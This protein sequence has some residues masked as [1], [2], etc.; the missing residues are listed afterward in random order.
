MKLKS[1]GITD[2]YG[3]EI[4]EGDILLVKTL[5][6]GGRLNEGVKVLVYSYLEPFELGF[7]FRVL[8]DN[9][10]RDYGVSYHFDRP[11]FNDVLFI[12]GQDLKTLRK[13]KGE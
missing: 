2:F 6:Y 9:F 11:D 4:K 12:V 1:T 13:I 5:S 3:N 10:G 8:P 7:R